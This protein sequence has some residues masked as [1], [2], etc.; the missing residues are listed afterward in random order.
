MDASCNQVITF[1]NIPLFH[2]SKY[3]FLTYRLEFSFTKML[4]S[5]ITEVNSVP[6]PFK[7]CFIN[8]FVP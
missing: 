2:Y 6:A 5:L 3:F 7:N 4:K 8:E 1:S